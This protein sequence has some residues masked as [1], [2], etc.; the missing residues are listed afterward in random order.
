MSLGTPDDQQPAVSST[1]P[2]NKPD[3]EHSV[4]FRGHSDN[5]REHSFN[6]REHPDNIIPEMDKSEIKTTDD[7][8]TIRYHSTRM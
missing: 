5:F 8:F 1:A 3:R 7:D 2:V 6:F 4:N